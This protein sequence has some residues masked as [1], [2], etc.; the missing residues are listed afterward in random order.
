MSL[1]ELE[2]E[3][4]AELKR[5]KPAI[6][7][8]RLCSGIARQLE[9]R[10]PDVRSLFRW[11][12]IALPAAAGIAVALFLGAP[13]DESPALTKSI[14]AVAEPAADSEIFVPIRAVNRLYDARYLG[15]VVTPDGG[16]ARKMVYRYFDTVTWQ[17]E[18][19]QATF[20]MTVP[21]DE[22]HFINVTGF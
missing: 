21:R 14:P 1:P 18:R 19:S 3:L 5:L 22:V 9:T 10:S 7:S 17:G 15:L 8:D 4:E 2:S 13:V 20:Q 11:S 16:R 6:A 12:A